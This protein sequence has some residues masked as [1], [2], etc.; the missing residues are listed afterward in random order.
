[1]AKIVWNFVRSSDSEVLTADVISFSR[2]RGK[3]NY[4]DNYTGQQITVTIRNNT[5][6]SANWIVGTRI[7][8]QLTAGS[9]GQTYWVSEVQY[10]DQPGTTTSSGTGSGSTATIVMDDWM[11][12]AGKIGVTNYALTAEF[13]YKQM[14][15]Q[16]TSGLGVLPS[17]MLWLT[18]YTGVYTAA[19]ATYTGT[20]AN[21]INLNLA[22]EKTGSQLYQSDAYL[23][24]RPASV[25]GSNVTNAATLQ[26]AKA[27]STGNTYVQY[28]GLKRIT[29]GQNF[30]N[31]ITVTPPVAAAQTAIDTGSVSTYGTRFNGISTV[32]DTT[33]QALDRAQW[34]AFSQSDPY[35]LHFEVTYTD[36]AQDNNGAQ[37]VLSNYVSGSAI[38]L[39]YVVPGSGVMTTT[40]CNIEG[41][42]YSATPDQ[43]LFTLYLT[44]NTVYSS[45]VLDSTAFGVLDQNR[46]GS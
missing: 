20:V 15:N 7:N 19:A 27:S 12:R 25:V 38:Y 13:S 33:A 16:F 40:L 5:N 2:F 36:I 35:A 37:Y 4:L 46:L 9:D 31:T 21:R 18:T 41:I 17:D 42:R 1:M 39:K 10:N 29:A 44:P 23:E 45:F 43:T 11:S 22:S 30:L 3:E 28:Q 26:P 32:N 6:Q 14:W 8:V 34:L 24:L